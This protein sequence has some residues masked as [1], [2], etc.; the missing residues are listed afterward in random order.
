MI[1]LALTLLIGS[2]AFADCPMVSPAVLKA[3]NGGFTVLWRLKNDASLDAPLKNG[4]LAS[5]E[6]W[7]KAHT[8]L[9]A[10]GLIENNIRVGR[11][12][13]KSLSSRD[14]FRDAIE[15][16]EKNGRLVSSGR[17]GRFHPI[18]CLESLPFRRL[19]AWV[20]LRTKPTEFLAT[21]LKRGNEI[22]VIADFYPND[23]S[24]AGESR[25][26]RH[27]KASLRQKGWSHEINFHNHPF[28][29]ANEYGDVGG[30]LAPST[31][32]VAMYQ[33]SRPAEAWITNGIDTVVF[34][35][36]SKFKP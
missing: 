16:N 31:A 2:M 17:V 10:R 34:T 9:D 4:E 6:R 27:A 1:F 8:S 22:A 23:Y 11:G 25:A 24:G 12:F 3:G 30:A 19:A 21:I 36:Y 18:S 20:D 33:S 5:Y 7:V 32:D 13:K 14:P 28:N 15:K 26:A 29:F 35:D